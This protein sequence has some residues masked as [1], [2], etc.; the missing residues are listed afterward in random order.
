VAK[1]ELEK[2]SVVRYEDT[3]VAVVFDNVFS[4]VVDV[5]VVREEDVDAAAV[6]FVNPTKV[7]VT[8]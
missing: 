2:F 3:D 6:E 7:V 8:V 5:K 4:V 1:R